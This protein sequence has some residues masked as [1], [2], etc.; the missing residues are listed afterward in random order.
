MDDALVLE[1]Y[2]THI[3]HIACKQHISVCSSTRFALY[4]LGLGIP[5]FLPIH[6]FKVRIRSGEEF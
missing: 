2:H 1:L 4:S 6:E 3:T 5:T